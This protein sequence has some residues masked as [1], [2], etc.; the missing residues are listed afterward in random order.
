MIR[1][2][3]QR[4]AE[5]C[6][7][8]LLGGDAETEFHGLSSDSRLLRAGEL[9]VA[10]SGARVD[11][12]DYV[13]QAAEQGAV[14]AIV[15]RP[16][17]GGVPQLVVDDSMTALSQLA[18]NWRHEQAVQVVGITGSNGKT[19]VKNLVASILSGQAPTLATRG[20]YNNEL[21]LPLTLCKLHAE[22]HYAVLEMGARHAG[23]IDVLAALAAPQ[24]GLVNNA[25]PAH[26]ET[27]GGLDGVA[28]AKG[29]MYSSLPAD[30]IAIINADDHYAPLWRGLAGKRRIIE[31]G[32]AAGAAVRTDDPGPECRIQ[33]PAGSFEVR[34]Q[35]HGPHNVMNALAATAI[36]IALDIP[37]DVITAGLQ[38]TDAEPGRMAYSESP[39][40]WLVIDD[41]YNANP[42]SLYAAISTVMQEAGGELWLVLGDMG[43]LGDG[44]RKLHAE[45][46]E[47]AQNLGVSRLYACGELCRE[48]VRGFGRGARHFASR[49]A[50][51]AALL[52]DIRPGVRCLVKGSRSA[53][54]EVVAAALRTAA[55]GTA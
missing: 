21:G 39:G 47:A 30:G 35:L 2:T 38:Q 28:R 12:H 4:A 40:G 49:E 7:A 55:G 1:Y 9:F 10:L 37:L 25:G 23:D 14:A 33:T 32:R 19:T 13:R 46:G 3:L 36:A 26:L 16:Q 51:T 42:A 52:D 5:L 50:L 53:G 45:M 18:A 29:E 15:E 27:F 20:N 54:M 24:V 31:F 43:E 41:A 6:F 34:L 44:E 8:Q 22:H 11:G 48:A 17:D